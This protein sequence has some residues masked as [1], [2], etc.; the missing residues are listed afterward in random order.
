[1]PAETA[2]DDDQASERNHGRESRRGA[3][4]PQLV[5]SVT[6]GLSAAAL[7]GIVVAA[8][9]A[10]ASAASADPST[11]TAVATA[12]AATAAGP[13]EAINQLTRMSHITCSGSGSG[14]GQ[15]HQS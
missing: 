11:T 7:A 8:C 6:F 12:P 5:P 10:A 2:I 15:G 14:Q 1:M 3:G 9:P 4:F 13:G